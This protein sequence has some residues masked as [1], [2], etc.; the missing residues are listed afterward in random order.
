M[1]HTYKGITPK[2]GKN[3]FIEDSAHVIGDV[4]LGD[5]CS[6]WFNTVIRGDV[7]YIRIGN[8]TNIQDGSIL[9][10]TVNTCP[11]V[12]GEG[13]TVGHGAILHGATI[14]NYCLIGMGAKILDKAIVEDFS[15]V[16]AGSLVKQGFVVPSGHLVAGVPARVIREITDDER[17]FLRQSAQN[18]INYMKDYK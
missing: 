3:C 12:L 18:Y 2:I 13:V 16:G 1:I 9:H 4:V 15:I 10:V 14:N 5:D 11:L 17:A 8:K 7:N 6:V